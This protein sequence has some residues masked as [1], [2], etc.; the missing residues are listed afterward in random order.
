MSQR[1]LGESLAREVYRAAI[2][3]INRK[4][5]D[6]GIVLQHHDECI[7]AAKNLANAVR[8]EQRV[9]S[10]VMVTI[11]LAILANLIELAQKV[12]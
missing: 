7:D 2:F 10:G 8:V 5:P 11:L 12:H 1:A 9:Y 4:D 3:A 6:L